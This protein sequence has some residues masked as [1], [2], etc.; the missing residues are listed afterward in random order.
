M[1]PLKS[2]DVGRLVLMLLVMVLSAGAGF[3]V[4]MWL[5]G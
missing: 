4:G 3:F 5:G 1:N 2:I